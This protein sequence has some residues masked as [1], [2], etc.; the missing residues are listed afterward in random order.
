[1]ADQVAYKFDKA[2]LKK[3]GMGMFWAVWPAAALAVVGYIQT[4]VKIDNPIII[5]ILAWL[6]PNIQNTIKQFI[7]GSITGD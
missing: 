1:M 4:E 3:I 5:A 6:L 7:K 2:S